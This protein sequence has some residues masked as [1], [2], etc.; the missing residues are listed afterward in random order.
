MLTA[1]TQAENMNVLSLL[2]LLGQ[3][4]DSNET[5]VQ[6]LLQCQLVDALN[7][8]LACPKHHTHHPVILAVICILEALLA[9]Y[10]HQEVVTLFQDKQVM[11]NLATI[12]GLAGQ[13]PKVVS[14]IG[15]LEKAAQGSQ[16]KRESIVVINQRVSLQN[17]PEA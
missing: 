11:T 1:K 7:D 5:A 10:D 4:V 2:S 6:V 8:I 9:N 16:N 17:Q 3:L 15:R 13:E 14:E 12:K